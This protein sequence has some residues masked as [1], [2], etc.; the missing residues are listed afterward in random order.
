V[1]IPRPTIVLVLVS[2][3]LS[4]AHAG[5]APVNMTVDQLIER[6]HRQLPAVR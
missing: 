3:C 1:T 2:A 4:A 5:P 6:L